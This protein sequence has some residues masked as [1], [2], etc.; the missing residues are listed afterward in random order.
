MN[1]PSPSHTVLGSYTQ[2]Q[3]WFIMSDER[4][5]GEKIEF[6]AES[7]T[8]Y[9]F[10]QLLACCLLFFCFIS[11]FLIQQVL[12]NSIH[13]FLL[14]PLYQSYHS[15]E[16]NIF[17]SIIRTKQGRVKVVKRLFVCFSLDDSVSVISCILVFLFWYYF[18]KQHWQMYKN[19]SREQWQNNLQAKQPVSLS[20]LLC[21]WLR[22]YN[23]HVINPP[24]GDAW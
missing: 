14:Y 19:W 17:P 8:S 21:P 15:V 16:R 20:A 4:K 3:F 12:Y 13:F 5:S 10:R 22:E 9:L 18:W 23:F 1:L 6:E 7:A 11:L 24:T 2:N